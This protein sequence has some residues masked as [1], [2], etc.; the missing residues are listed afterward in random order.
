VA[1][2]RKGDKEVPVNLTIVLSSIDDIVV[3][4]AVILNKAVDMKIRSSR[5]I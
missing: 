4:E 3:F 2:K 1:N 5:G